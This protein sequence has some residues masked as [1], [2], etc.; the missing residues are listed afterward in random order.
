MIQDAM[1]SQRGPR[2]ATVNFDT[3]QIIQQH[4]VPSLPRNNFLMVVIK[5]TRKDG[6]ENAHACYCDCYS[7]G[8]NT[9]GRDFKFGSVVTKALV[10][11]TEAE[12]EAR[13]S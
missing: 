4:R 10:V 6:Y 8:S 1:L 11:E 12:A 2:D 9:C 13:G 7:K 3:Y 5:R